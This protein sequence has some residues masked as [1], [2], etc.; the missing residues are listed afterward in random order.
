MITLES[1]VALR[2]DLIEFGK[3]FKVPLVF[4]ATSKEHASLFLVI[5]TLVINCFH[6]F[7]IGFIS[8]LR[9]PHEIFSKFHWFSR[10]PLRTTPFFFKSR[11]VENY[12]K[13]ERHFFFN[14]GQ[15]KFF[16]SPMVF[17]RSSEE[18]ASVFLNHFINYLVLI[19]FNLYG[20]QIFFLKSCW[21]LCDPLRNRL[22]FF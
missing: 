17:V 3:I 7:L 21:F 4:H 12:S 13:S 22:L 5:I 11:S 10:D 9:G 18:Q 16:Q 2:G 19:N 1:H 15:L 6:R 14:L 20:S 8:A